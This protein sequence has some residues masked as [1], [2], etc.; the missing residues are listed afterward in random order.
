[1]SP[2]EKPAEGRMVMELR[3][4]DNPDTVDRPVGENQPEPQTPDEGTSKG[5]PAGDKPTGKEGDE[6]EIDL[7]LSSSDTGS[8]SSADEVQDK[9]ER[10]SKKQK[11]K[12]TKAAKIRSKKK[13]RKDQAAEAIARG[14][15]PPTACKKCGEGYWVKKCSKEPGET[16]S[17]TEAGPSRASPSSGQDDPGDDTA[18]ETPAP[19]QPLTPSRAGLSQRCCQE[20]ILR[21]TG[22]LDRELRIP[23]HIRQSRIRNHE[24]RLIR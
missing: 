23:W 22:R 11:R 21:Q 7:T 13:E 9:E 1:M 16:A 15:P 14:D 17:V 4:R 12:A 6:M 2:S 3:R 10:V 24:R 8:V 5:P 18:T 19:P 20:L